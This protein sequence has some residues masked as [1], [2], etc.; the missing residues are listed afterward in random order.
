MIPRKVSKLLTAYVDGELSLRQR[1]AVRHWLRRSSKAR[2]LYRQMKADSLALQTLPWPNLKQD[3]S[4]TILD[5]ISTTLPDIQLPAAGLIGRLRG[6]RPLWVAAAAAVLVAVGVGSYAFFSGARDNDTGPLAATPTAPELLAHPADPVADDVEP[7]RTSPESVFAFPNLKAPQLQLAQ[8]RVP[9]IFQV[10]DLQ[11]PAEAARLQGQLGRSPM[12][13]L[14]LFAARSTT[15][16]SRLRAVC[17]AEGL[18]VR[19]DPASQEFVNRGLERTWALYVENIRPDEVA[20]ILTRLSIDDKKLGEFQQAVLTDV[21]ADELAEVLGGAGKDLA[22]PSQRP[23]EQGT[24]GQIVSSLPGQKP[25][26]AS[27]RQLIVVPHEPLREAPYDEVKRMLDGYRAARPGT[28]QL[29]LVLWS[30]D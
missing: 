16:L 22:P 9:R 19:I 29:L 15:A 4:D 2:R 20:R 17:K 23:V 21:T 5:K 8:V 26:Q 28:L 11:R 1:R 7:R 13:R 27:P 24:A 25:D 14:D 12:F 3:L 18:E 10:R 6:L 30:S